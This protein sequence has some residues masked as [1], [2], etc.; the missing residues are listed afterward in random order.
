MSKLFSPLRLGQLELTHRI[1]TTMRARSEP[2]LA[3]YARRTTSGGLV[4][5]EG[6]P[7]KDVDQERWKRI[8]GAIHQ[9]GGLVVA[10]VAPD[11]KEARPDGVD[12]E[13]VMADVQ[14]STRLARDAGFDAIE[15]DAAANSL[16]ERFLRPETNTREDAYGRDDEGRMRFLLEAT[17]VL[18]EEFSGERVGVRLAPR[19]RQCQAEVFA[20]AMRAISERELAYVHLAHV[21]APPRRADGQ[22]AL[23]VCAERQAFR[24]DVSCALIVSDYCEVAVAAHAVDS[25][26]ADAVGFL[27]VN[28]DPEFVAR[29]LASRVGERQ[30]AVT[31]SRER[32]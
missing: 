19:A 9:A 30:G 11:P 3:E 28:D 29:S 18:A 14:R 23:A 22:S 5:A 15:L 6:C 10:L 16:P 17:H 2:D 21:D 27:E 31:G 13:A 25:R 8:C 7:T 4:I 32:G 1:V 24:S 20:G 12:V 26:W